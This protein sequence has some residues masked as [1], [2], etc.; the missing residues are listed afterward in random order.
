MKSPL[1]FS[2][3][4]AWDEYEMSQLL[5]FP[6]LACIECPGDEMLE[7]VEDKMEYKSL[8]ECCIGCYVE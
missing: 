4:S 2:R 1:L 6:R 5:F 3:G 8:F 7:L